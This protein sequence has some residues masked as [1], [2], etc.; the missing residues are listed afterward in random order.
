[1][2]GYIP[3]RFTAREQSPIQVVTGAVSINYVDQANALTTTL[4]RHPRIFRPMSDTHK[5]KFTGTWELGS[6]LGECCAI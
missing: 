4:C 2:A 6:I 5:Y 3:R 1:M